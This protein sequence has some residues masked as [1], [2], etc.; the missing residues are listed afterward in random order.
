MSCNLRIAEPTP[1]YYNWASFLPL[2]LRL[3]CAVAKKRL[4]AITDKMSN[5]CNYVEAEFLCR[6]ILAHN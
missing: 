6:A 5:Y 2:T 3:C 1:D 4:I